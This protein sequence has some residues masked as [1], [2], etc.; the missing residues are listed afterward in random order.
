MSIEV[1]FTRWGTIYL[2]AGRV[3]V[4]SMVI[5]A[6]SLFSFNSQP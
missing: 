4:Q 5:V 2:G 6:H 3:I 1:D